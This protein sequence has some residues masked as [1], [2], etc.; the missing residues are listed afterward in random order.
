MSRTANILRRQIEQAFLE[1]PIAV[2][3][4]ILEYQYPSATATVRFYL[5]G[6][7]EPVVLSNIP[8]RLTFGGV[9][10]GQPKPGD[11]CIVTFQQNGN[12]A[13]PFITMIT[14]ADNPA[15]IRARQDRTHSGGELPLGL[16]DW[17]YKDVG[18]RPVF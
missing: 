17:S 4:T 15:R 9:V 7:E 6:S 14:S 5:P 10:E 1:R 12:A 3:G 13:Q 8:V 2:H 16:S 18:G 11:E